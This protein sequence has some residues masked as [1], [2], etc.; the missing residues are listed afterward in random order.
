MNKVKKNKAGLGFAE[1]LTYLS[2]VISEAR[3]CG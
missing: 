2:R 1:P 3:V